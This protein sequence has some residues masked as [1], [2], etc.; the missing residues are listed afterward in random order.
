MMYWNLIF[1]DLSFQ[2]LIQYR[3]SLYQEVM[4]IDINKIG[5]NSDTPLISHFDMPLSGL[6]HSI[7][8]LLYC[9]QYYFLF[10]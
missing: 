4:G 7:R 3:M 5:Y 8:V 9:E 10:I 2:N 6:N 1:V